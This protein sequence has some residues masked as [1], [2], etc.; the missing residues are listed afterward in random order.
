MTN[1]LE[2]FFC[3]F[4]DLLYSQREASCFRGE[5]IYMYLHIHR[6]SHTNMHTHM[7]IHYF[8][9]PKMQVLQ[10]SFSVRCG[11]GCTKLYL[12]L[13]WQ[14]QAWEKSSWGLEEPMQEMPGECHFITSNTSPPSTGT[15]HPQQTNSCSLQ[16]MLMSSRQGIEKPQGWIK[17]KSKEEPGDLV[18]SSLLGGNHS[19]IGYLSNRLERSL[20]QR[21]VKWL[22][23]V[24][25]GQDTWLSHGWEWFADPCMPPRQMFS[26]PSSC[27]GENWPLGAFGKHIPKWWCLCVVPMVGEQM[28]A[29]PLGTTPKVSPGCQRKRAS[30][31]KHKEE[32]EASRGKAQQKAFMRTTV[33]SKW[34]LWDHS[35]AFPRVPSTDFP[36]VL[37]P[38]T[39]PCDVTVLTTASRR[40]HGFC[41]NLNLSFSQA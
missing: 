37:Q 22:W 28:A 41:Q 29:Q 27:N 40:C 25:N 9:L 14:L 11:P 38:E 26:L 7:Q 20:Q 12:F 18:F 8:F 23:H 5:N 17:M 39:S 35:W 16:G 10:N 30:N 31:G 19:G 1:C 4:K 13:P 15:N 2:R 24:S 36:A 6:R 34:M 3:I 32:R 21:G 33:R